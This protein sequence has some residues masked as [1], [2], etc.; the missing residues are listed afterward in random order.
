MALV[1][2]GGGAR[3]IAHIGAIEELERR[4]YRIGSVA[5]TSMGALV[6]GMYAAGH[7]DRFREWLC[8][9][10]RYKVFSLVDFSLS[11]DGLVKG[12]RVIAA[13][14]QLVPDVRIERR[15][16]GRSLPHGHLARPAAH[17][18]P[19]GPGYG[20]ALRQHRQDQL[21]DLGSR[22]RL[23]GRS[24]RGVRHGRGRR[25]DPFFFSHTV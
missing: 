21:L 19:P 23:P 15:R 11:T 18:H 1:L 25:S 10:D 7:L 24:R 9:L 22:S 5:G 3:G 14:K 2:G 20:R 13:L 6:G 17:P 4:G 16:S 8:T 12:D